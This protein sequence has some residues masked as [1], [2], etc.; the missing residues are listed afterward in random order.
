MLLHRKSLAFVA[1]SGE[2]YLISGVSKCVNEL[3]F[4][5]PKI[6]KFSKTCFTTKETALAPFNLAHPVYARGIPLANASN[7]TMASKKG[8]KRSIR[9]RDFYV[10]LSAMCS[11]MLFA[12]RCTQYPGQKSFILCIPYKCD[13]PWHLPSWQW[14]LSW[15]PYRPNHS[16]SGHSVTQT[17]SSS[18]QLL[19]LFS[20]S[21]NELSRL[22]RFVR[23]C[24]VQFPRWIGGPGLQCCQLVW[25]TVH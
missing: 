1:P 18:H 6:I 19:Q 11:A 17:S 14:Q 21:V 5:L 7:D 13:M 4:H 24:M 16:R 23:A 22:L 3:L 15:S 2:K 8:E 9:S 20:S 25:N 10:M 12:S